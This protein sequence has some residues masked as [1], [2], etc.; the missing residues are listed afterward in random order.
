MT[1][2]ETLSYVSIGEGVY[3]RDFRALRCYV[4]GQKADGYWHRLREESFNIVMFA[5]GRRSS[6][7]IQTGDLWENFIQNYIP[8][9]GKKVV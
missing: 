4:A 6:A 2:L 3:S 1:D 9:V 8:S 7:W 5:L